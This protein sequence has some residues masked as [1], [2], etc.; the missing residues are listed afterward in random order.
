MREPRGLHATF[1]ASH[2]AIRTVRPIES[3]AATAGG[4]AP[5]ATASPVATEGDHRGEQNAGRGSRGSH[6][7][8]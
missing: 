4:F 8:E 1:D 3:R 5:D 7:D 6:H 2:E